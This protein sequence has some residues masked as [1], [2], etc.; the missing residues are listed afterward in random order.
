MTAPHPLNYTTNFL[1]GWRVPCRPPPER[2]GLG[3]LVVL[4]ALVSLGCGFRQNGRMQN[5]PEL[6]L[7]LRS[8]SESFNKVL[9]VMVDEF[10]RRMRA[11]EERTP[12][13]GVEPYVTKEQVARHLDVTTRTIENWARESAGRRYAG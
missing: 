12:G 13:G 7:A 10:D 11:F 8:L 2:S 5:K 1:R 9:T 4:L 6:E 3:A